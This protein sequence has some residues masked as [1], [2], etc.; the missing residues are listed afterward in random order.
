[1]SLSAKELSIRLGGIN[2]LTEM[3]QARL[4]VSPA[5]QNLMFSNFSKASI[6]AGELLCS[7]WEGQLSQL[8]AV[9]KDYTKVSI[10]GKEFMKV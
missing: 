2:H 6:E 4:V 3:V 10:S 5:Q 9:I 8:E 1:M 7:Q